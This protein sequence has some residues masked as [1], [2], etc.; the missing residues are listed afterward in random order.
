VTRFGLAKKLMQRKR[1]QR[2]F[3]KLS[4]WRKF[5]KTAFRYEW[6]KRTNLSFEQSLTFEPGT[7]LSA[8]CENVYDPKLDPLQSPDYFK[9]MNNQLSGFPINSLLNS[10]FGLQNVSCIFW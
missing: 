2:F 7:L 9:R 8:Q 6:E 1:I 10:N 4:G 5:Y 3:G